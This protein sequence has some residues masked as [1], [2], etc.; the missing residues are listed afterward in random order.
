[1]AI[2][3]FPPVSRADKNGLIAVGGDLEPES[4][5]LAYQSGIFPWPMDEDTITWFS[6]PTRGVVFLESFTVSKSTQRY[7]KKTPFNYKTDSDFRS[8]IERCS[9]VVNRGRQGGTWITPQMLEAYCDFFDQGHCHS[10]ETYLNGELVG[11]MYGVQIGRYFSAESSFY[12]VPNASKGAMCHM[13]E[14]LRG[15]GIAWF[16]C[17]QVTPFSK[18]FGATEL[19]RDQFLEL[20]VNTLETSS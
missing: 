18:S 3:R 13:V 7:L 15:Q 11:G 10:F 16:D 20:L 19:K 6:P 17:Q 4:L 14:Y 5:L 12:R 8:V 9:E 1:M 2:S